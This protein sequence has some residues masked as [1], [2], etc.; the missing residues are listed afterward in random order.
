MKNS[1]KILLIALLVFSVGLALFALIA[2]REISRLKADTTTKA[3]YIEALHVQMADKDASILELKRTDSLLKLS[4]WQLEKQYIAKISDRD[5]IIND[6]KKERG[7][8]QEMNDDESVA[9]F[10]N[11]TIPGSCITP[12]VGLPDDSLYAIKV[13]NIRSANDIFID[14]DELKV[15]NVNLIQSE[16]LLLQQQSNL[17]LRIETKDSQIK[18]MQGYRQLKDTEIEKLNGQLRDYEKM[19]RRERLRGNLKAIGVGVVGI[20]AFTL[21]ILL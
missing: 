7:K 8:V 5:K 13:D 21:S 16:K 17:V 10:M 3:G 2:K 15:Q 11:Y 14:R 1:V 6:F 12:V 4:Q 18:E 20:S 19:V 9:Y